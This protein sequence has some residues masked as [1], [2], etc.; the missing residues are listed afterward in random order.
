MLTLNGNVLP[1][2]KEFQING[3]VY[4]KNWLRISTRLEKQAIGI[5]ESPAPAYY[6]RRFYTAPGVVKPFD[7]LQASYVKENKLTTR[8][9]LSHTDWEVIKAIDPSSAISA[10][11][12]A[13]T[14][15]RT[16]LRTASNVKEAAILACTTT[17]Q[18]EIYITSAAYSTWPTVE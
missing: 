1:Y 16:D 17:E 3:V 14:T 4:P 9:K 12:A 6:D 5:V 7:D 18:L 10:V 15:V 2:D 13:I 11:A 8:E